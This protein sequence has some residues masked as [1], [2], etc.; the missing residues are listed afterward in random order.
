MMTFN[1]NEIQFAACFDCGLFFFFDDANSIPGRDQ[2]KV[3]H[4]TRKERYLLH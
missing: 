3:F 2:L 4:V 1:C